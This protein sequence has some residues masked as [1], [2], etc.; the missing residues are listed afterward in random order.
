MG[1]I[2]TFLSDVQP[3]V[4]A[5]QTR[6]RARKDRPGRIDPYTLSGAAIDTT[7]SPRFFSKDRA[8]VQKAIA[9]DRQ[10]QERLFAAHTTRLYRTAFAILRNKEDAE[11]AVQEGLCS[12]YMKLRTFQG[13]SSFSSWL[14][15]IVVNAALMNR[16]RKSAHPEAC[17]DEFLETQE[18]RVARQIADKRPDP[19]EICSASEIHGLV[20]K[21]IQK[22]PE[23]IRRAYCLQKV[24]GFSLDESIQALGIRR[25]AFKSRILRARLRLKEELRYSLL[26]PVQRAS[27]VEAQGSNGTKK[28]RQKDNSGLPQG[29]RFNPTVPA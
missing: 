25:S 16:R 18:E 6:Q 12:A 24:D 8:L 17:L 1:A 2:Q 5:L 11:D 4:S 22:L 26:A 14:H 13:M 21:E 10:S 29:M 28:W 7:I 23:G 15:R 20:E 19:E 9:G 27:A 3:P